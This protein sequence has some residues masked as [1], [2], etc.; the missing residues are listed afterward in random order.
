MFLVSQKAG[1]FPFHAINFLG[2]L[3]SKVKSRLVFKTDGD[4]PDNAKTN[5]SD[6]LIQ[7]TAP[8]LPDKFA[9]QPR[10]GGG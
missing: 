4:S 8:V 7:P 9:I 3:D 2:R 5:F 6:N 1:P 10:R